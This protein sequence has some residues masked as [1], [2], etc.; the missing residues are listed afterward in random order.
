MT[1]CVS[2]GI[3]PLR[4]SFPPALSWGLG[5][6]RESRPESSSVPV[7]QNEKERSPTTLAGGTQ[8]GSCPAYPGFSV[9]Q[10]RCLDLRGDSC[11]GHSGHSPQ[12][13]K[14]LSSESWCG[15][16]WEQGLS[17][18]GAL[19]KPRPGALPSAHTDFSPPS[20]RLSQA[21]GVA[22]P[23]VK[24]SDAPPACGPSK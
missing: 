3:Q 6:G 14:S 15:H 12:S 7:G 18:R 17:C 8:E 21:A 16:P 20:S 23:R 13:L 19:S 24:S 11:P 22:L 4:R 1:H 9:V 5:W 2:S 10:P